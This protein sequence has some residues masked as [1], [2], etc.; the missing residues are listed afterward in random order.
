MSWQDQG[1]QEHGWFGH[2]LSDK[3]GH[4]T[5][6]TGKT[7]PERSLAVAYGALAASP[8]AQRKRIETQ[9]Q[10][11]TLGRFA[12]AMTAWMRG[13]ALDRRRFASLFFD[14]MADDPVVQALHGAAAVASLATSPAEMRQASESVAKAIGLVG[15]DAWPR[16][17][18]QAQARVNNSATMEAVE[19]GLQVDQARN[20]SIRPDYPLKTASAMA[21]AAKV[22]TDVAASDTALSTRGSKDAELPAIKAGWNG[23]L[24]NVDQF[25]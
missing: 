2:G 6:D 21:I 25:G 4:D 10:Y 7:P 1:R 5:T 18:V 20:N 15:I 17:V 19:R 16:F 3:A 23:G 22:T 24:D 13:A 12:E 9:F 8:P 11:D 14:R